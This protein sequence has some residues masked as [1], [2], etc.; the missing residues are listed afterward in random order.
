LFDLLRRSAAGVRGSAV[1]A[2]FLYALGKAL[3]DLGEIDDAFDAFAGGAALVAAERAYDAGADRRQ[4]AAMLEEWEDITLPPFVRTRGEAPVFVT[5][6]PRSGTTLVEQILA[7]HPAITG[8][9]EL[10]LLSMVA[11][12]ADGTGPGVLGA[13]KNAVGFHPLAGLYKRLCAERFGVGDRVTDKSLDIGRMLGFVTAILPSA[14]I[15]WVRRQ[16]MDAAWS[17]FRTYFARGVPWSWALTSIAEHFIIEDQMF[18]FWNDRLGARLLIV[19]YAALVTNPELLISQIEAHAGLDHDP[20]TLT[21]HL[22][23]RSV[24]TSSVAQVRR[25]I[26]RDAIN[27]AQVY[28]HRLSSFLDIYDGAAR[29]Q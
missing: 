12:E 21:P 25:P 17:C 11:R 22:T 3:D 29:T 8:G 10:N 4:A 27:S 15:I 14:P 5:G 19:D 6:L 26:H 18:V 1:R 23:R 9:G 13:H 2:P 24:L 28:K 16:A 7:S 20:L